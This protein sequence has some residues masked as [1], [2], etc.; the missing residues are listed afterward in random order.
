M[1]FGVGTL[2]TNLGKAIF[3][4]RVRTT[5]ATYTVAPKFVALGVGATGAGRTAAVGDT[6]LS[7]EQETRVSG[8]ESVVTGSVTGDTYQVQG[9][10]SIN[11]TRAIDEAGLF[12][13]S[14]SGHMFASA[15]MNVISVVAGD[16]VQWTWQIRLS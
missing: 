2:V 12:D 3:A 13:A 7:S 14:T 10:Q 1:P 6:A 9:T 11:G 16:S 4:D 15:T 5:P 8:T